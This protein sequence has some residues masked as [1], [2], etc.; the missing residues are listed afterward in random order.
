[1]NK[2]FTYLLIFSGLIWIAGCSTELEVNAPYVER[3]IIYCV[4]D[5]TLAFQTVRL[6]KGFLNK[7][8]SALEI[9]KNSPDSILYKPEDILVELIEST[10]SKPENRKWVMSSFTSNGKEE[11][12]FYS[13]EQLLYKTV[14]LK[15]D[16]T[17]LGTTRYKI[18]V[19]NKVTNH[20]SE[21]STNLVGRNFTITSPTPDNP[22]DPINFFSRTKNDIKVNIAT[23]TALCEAYINFYVKVTREKG[24]ISETS[25]ETWS[26]TS[27][28]LLG[29]TPSS[30]AATGS[31]GLDL[32]W[33]FLQFKVD[34]QKN[35]NVTGRKIQGG[36]IQVFGANEEYERYKS[37]NGN[38]NPITQSTPIYTNVTNGLG[39]LCS[40][41]SKSFPMNLDLKTRDLI[42]SKVPE[43]KLIK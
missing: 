18:R 38:Y 16:S 37:V 40:R 20:V 15:L 33:Q 19:I 17:N 42:N 3:K 25:N 1:M 8:R 21:A 5:P 13:P 32:L 27:P 28:G 35:E 41:N 11:G 4:L 2:P 6:S 10:S 29:S 31:V 23:N 22:N 7:G 14:D 26:M 24:G 34:E 12:I 43:F 9:A 30:P 39:I 36:F